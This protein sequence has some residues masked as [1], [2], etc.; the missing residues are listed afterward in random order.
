MA[1]RLPSLHFEQGEC[2][3]T[4]PRRVAIPLSVCLLQGATEQGLRRIVSSAPTL[5]VWTI[6]RCYQRSGRVVATGIEAGR[7]LKDHWWQLADVDDRMANPVTSLEPSTRGEIPWQCDPLMQIGLVASR[8]AHASGK[9]EGICQQAAWLALVNGTRQ[10]LATADTRGA[11]SPDS[12]PA[13]ELL[14]G[15][16][17][18][19]LEKLHDD[20][21]TRDPVVLLA[22]DSLRRAEQALTSEGEAETGASRAIADLPDW[23]PDRER[24]DSIAVP[25]DLVQLAR[26]VARMETME[27]DFDRQLEEEKLR[28]LKELAQGAGHEINNPLAN[29]S[30]RAQSLL[31]SESDPE[32]QLML[33]TINSQAFR[34]NEMIADM[35]LFARPPRMDNRPV[36]VVT[37]VQQAVE[38]IRDRAIQA[39]VAIRVDQGTGP[40]MVDGDENHLVEAIKAVC[41]NS[42]EAC[43]HGGL[44][45]LAIREQSPD[46]QGQ[47]GVVTIEVR[48]DGPGIPAEVRPHIFNP[49]YSGREAGRGLGFGL[50][51]SWRIITQ[52]GG[53]IEVERPEVGA[54][55]V[56]SLPRAENQAA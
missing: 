35:M 27:A 33:A 42:L 43:A 14:P 15:S 7:W 11:F 16:F 37:L 29:I 17:L 12:H 6:C 34:A 4:L 55:L 41:V 53:R 38:D 44:V 46:G 2:Q 36:N 52:H 45:E 56:I 51:K 13:D 5:A 9:A 49:F 54:R 18:L 30:L 32:R 24:D 3:L 50:S 10:W 23:L 31:Q 8:L 39:G 22:R 28:A 25:V 1:S 19:L 48:D 26:R 47:Q 21:A 20:Q 40:L